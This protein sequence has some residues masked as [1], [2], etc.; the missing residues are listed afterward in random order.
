M[1]P[2]AHVLPSVADRDKEIAQLDPPLEYSPGGDWR[3]LRLVEPRS[4]WWQ[5]LSRGRLD[6]AIDTLIVDGANDRARLASYGEFEH[7]FNRAFAAGDESEQ[8]LGV[9]NPLFDYDPL[10]RPVFFR[11]LAVQAVLYRALYRAGT[12]SE[13]DVTLDVV[14]SWLRLDDELAD[15]FAR[16]G[17]A[18]IHELQRATAAYLDR[19]VLPTSFPSP[20]SQST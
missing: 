19:R 15:E 9:A 16:A 8:L 17:G 3:R 7:Q 4:H 2:G 13:P 12:R 5:G 20:R 18:S 1:V 14:A 10:E 11:L 6:N